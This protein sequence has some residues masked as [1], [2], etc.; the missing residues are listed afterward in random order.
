M[1]IKKLNP[2]QETDQNKKLVKAH[3]QFGK[4][5]NELE[6]KELTDQ[7]AHSVNSEIDELNSTSN[8]NFRKK[9]RKSQTKILRLVE[10]ELKIVP[11]N[12]YRNLWMGLG[13]AAFGVPLGVAFGASMG[14]M[15]FLG[16][17]LPIGLAI[18]TAVGMSMDKKAMEEKRQLDIEVEL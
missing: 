18:G 11:K 8:D 17:G 9:L 15:A 7:I 13:M 3:T 12:Y 5:L 10:K 4:L 1:E 6:K 14:N 2:I 16:I